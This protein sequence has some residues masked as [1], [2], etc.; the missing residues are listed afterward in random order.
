M[1]EDANKELIRNW[2]EELFNQGRLEAAEKYIAPD[3]VNHNAFPG[4]VPGPDGVRDL[5]AT[6]RGGFPDLHGTLNRVLSEG[7]MVATHLTMRGTHGGEFMGIPASGRTITANGMG[8]Y[9]IENGKIAEAWV[10]FDSADLLRQITDTA[11]SP[12]QEVRVTK[13]AGK[14]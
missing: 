5:V 9:R 14:D 10:M 6:F 13:P 12:D 7:E 11:A 8:M 4:Q 3:F 1:S 2:A